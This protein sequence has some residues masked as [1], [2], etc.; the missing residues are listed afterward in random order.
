MKLILINNLLDRFERLTNNSLENVYDLK[1]LEI[2]VYSIIK[3]YKSKCNLIEDDSFIN[4]LNHIALDVNYEIEK[5]F[6]KVDE[7]KR[8]VQ[9]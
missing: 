1:E 9:L 4:I 7:K 5:A 8:G 6:E 3:S 2:E